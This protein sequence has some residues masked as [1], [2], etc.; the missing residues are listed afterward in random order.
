MDNF[1][2]LNTRELKI[3]GLEEYISENEISPSK[4]NAMNLLRI[5][6]EHNPLFGKLKSESSLQKND[7]LLLKNQTKRL[8]E[9][10]R[11]NK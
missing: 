6:E 1:I 11:T 4:I 2:R 9:V 8:A 5:Y 3:L 10:S 7:I